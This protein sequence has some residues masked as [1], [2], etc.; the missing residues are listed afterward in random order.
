MA[1]NLFERKALEQDSGLL[2]ERWGQGGSNIINFTDP[3][4][5]DEIIHTVSS[6]KRLF[7]KSFT[8]RS[9][10]A[11]NSIFVKDGGAGGTSKYQFETTVLGEPYIIIFDVPLFFDTDVYFA[12]DVSMSVSFQGWEE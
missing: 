9:S 5:N 7:I 1:L 2:R 10:G 12:T 4:I 8:F 3:T 11:T 6:Q